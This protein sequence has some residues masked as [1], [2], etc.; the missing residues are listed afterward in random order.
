M[1]LLDDTYTLFY[2]TKHSQSTEPLPKLFCPKSYY[3]K[4]F[5]LIVQWKKSENRFIL[6]FKCRLNFQMT[7]L[8][9]NHSVWTRKFALHYDSFP[10]FDHFSFKN[11]ECETT[12]LWKIRQRFG[13]FIYYVSVFSVLKVSKKFPFIYYV[14]IFLCYLDSLAPYFQYY[15]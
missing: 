10:I 6:S 4:L 5:D 7:L 8:N 1:D 2:V 9:M 15:K 12:Q 3:R 14:S 11:F 13:Q